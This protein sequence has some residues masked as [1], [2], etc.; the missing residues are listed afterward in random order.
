[1]YKLKYSIYTICSWDKHVLRLPNMLHMHIL[2]ND[3][4]LMPNKA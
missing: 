3:K 4:I 1:M 2:A